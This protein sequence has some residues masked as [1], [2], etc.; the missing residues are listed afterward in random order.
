MGPCSVYL[1]QFL[2][3]L[4]HLIYD[5]TRVT[6]S[7]VNLTLLNVAIYGFTWS[8]SWVPYVLL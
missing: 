4:A 1:F 2:Q 8:T 3:H 5:S 7:A 6:V